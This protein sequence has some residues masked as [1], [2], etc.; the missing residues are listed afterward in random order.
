MH[1]PTHSHSCGLYQGFPDRVWLFGLCYQ[2]GLHS[3]NYIHGNVRARSILVGQNLTVKLWGLGPAL[4]RKMDTG[5]A[6]DVEDIE[7]RRWQAPEVS[8]RQTLQQSS[9]MSSPL[10]QHHGQ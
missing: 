2:E 6:E 8:A 9:D 5:S 7:M 10:H 4:Y 1:G 3:K